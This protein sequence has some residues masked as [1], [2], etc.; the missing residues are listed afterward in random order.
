M[1]CVNATPM[2]FSHPECQRQ[3][4]VCIGEVTPRSF[5]C[6]CR[7]FSFLCWNRWGERQ[8]KKLRVI[9]ADTAKLIFTLHTL[10]FAVQL[11]LFSKEGENTS[12]LRSSLCAAYVWNTL[13]M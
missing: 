10:Q 5:P 11:I 8:R 1:C 2:A 3:K 6:V 12:L 9:E 4:S 13:Q 7:D